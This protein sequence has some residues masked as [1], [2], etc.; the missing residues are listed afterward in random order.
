MLF[1]GVVMRRGIVFLFFFFFLLP[2][3]SIL[4]RWNCVWNVYLWGLFCPI[5]GIRECVWW[6]RW[7]FFVPFFIEPNTTCCPLTGTRRRISESGESR[8]DERCIF[9]SPPSP[10]SSLSLHG[11]FVL[12]DVLMNYSLALPWLLTFDQKR[13][14]VNTFIEPG[15]IKSLN[16]IKIAAW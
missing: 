11:P 1:L 4:D 5:E 10:P 13:L 8:R 6:Y 3:E 7:S 15:Y 9:F 2:F 16:Q 14:N 12:N